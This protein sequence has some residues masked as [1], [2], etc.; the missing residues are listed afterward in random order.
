MDQI[1]RMLIDVQKNPS[2]LIGKPS[3]NRLFYFYNAFAYQ[4]HKLG[5]TS[6][7]ISDF[8]K[9][10]Q[11]KYRMNADHHWAKIISFFC[12]S[13]E[14]AFYEFYKHLEK[15]FEE[16]ANLSCPE[17]ENTLSTDTTTDSLLY[18]EIETIRKQPE[19]FLGTQSLEGLYANLCGY[20]YFL[21][22]NT[23][24]TNSLFPDFTKFIQNKFHIY[25][26]NHSWADIL[27][28]IYPLD[29]KAFS[30]FYTYWDEFLTT[31]GTSRPSQT[32][33]VGRY[34]TNTTD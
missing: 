26:P 25:T 14:Q 30:M 27:L 22:R 13:D 7:I 23:A 16:Y 19:L 11:K 32:S 34:R 9:Y 4:F 6:C 28:F 17:K 15:F 5:Y 21:D 24:P 2:A 12:I 31:A 33:A 3:L 10:I 20:N 1:H 29:S 8:Q 18:M